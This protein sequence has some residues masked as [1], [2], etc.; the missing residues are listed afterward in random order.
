MRVE[1]QID[2]PLD[3]PPLPAMSARGAR[4]VASGAFYRIDQTG[5]GR[6]TVYRLADGRYALRLSDFYVSPNVDLELRL[7]PRQAPKSTPEF[8]RAPS[9]F[10]ARLDVTAGSLNFVVPRGV[11]PTRYRS[12]VVWCPPTQNAYAA[13]TLKPAR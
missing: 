5:K 6:V 7:S 3:E 10:V 2:V 9:A 1:Q 4:T 8:M 13:A 11:D 12:L